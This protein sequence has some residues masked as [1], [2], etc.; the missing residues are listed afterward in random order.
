VTPKQ[1]FLAALEAAPHD[2]RFEKNLVGNVSV[3][4]PDGVM[5]GYI[6]LRTLEYVDVGAP[7]PADMTE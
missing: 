1:Q 3:I 7:D 6:D 5:R 2:A 4:T